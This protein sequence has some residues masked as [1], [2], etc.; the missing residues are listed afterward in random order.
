MAQLIDESMSVEELTEIMQTSY[1][2][3]C[4]KLDKRTLKQCQA[5]ARRHIK[6]R[7]KL[8]HG[9]KWKWTEGSRYKELR[10]LSGLCRE[11]EMDV[12]PEIAQAKLELWVEAVLVQRKMN[13]E[14]TL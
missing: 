10:E 2:L 4:K 9:L 8:Y 11:V 12:M 6:R 5:V 13:N 14:T 1:E 7:I 3:I